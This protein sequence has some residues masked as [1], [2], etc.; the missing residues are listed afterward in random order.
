MTRAFILT[1]LVLS[2]LPLRA[3]G[4][5]ASG[6][7]QDILAPHSG[8]PAV[9]SPGGA[10][11]VVLTTP[12]DLVLENGELRYSLRAD[13][14][15]LPGD[16][17]G[18]TVPLP[19][20]VAPGRYALA[21]ADGRDRNRAAVFVLAE[22]PEV[23]ALA[24]LAGPQISAAEGENHGAEAA[25][26]KALQANAA[27]VLMSGP[28]TGSNGSKEYEA[29][30]AWIEMQTTPIFV[31]PGSQERQDGLWRSYFGAPVDG[32]RFGP[33]G[34]M[35]LGLLDAF[36]AGELD[37][38]MGAIQRLRRVLKPQ[39]WVVGFTGTNV[40]QWGMRSQLTLLADDPIDALLVGA[41]QTEASP[42]EGLMPWGATITLPAPPA[43]SGGVHIIDMT[44][45]AMLPRPDGA[46]ATPG[47]VP[48]EASSAAADAP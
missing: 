6:R 41:R 24:H 45:A 34:F 22:M 44:H 42:A 33:D 9:L 43:E 25:L 5:D 29:L 38:D 15:S 47:D 31:S 30:I 32:F 2:L 18:D 46:E 19:R 10:L 17:V 4:R 13:W 14:R 35:A 27:L 21:Y 28:L 26:A 40:M 16:R 36:G 11:E 37:G 23:Y 7:L 39:R 48:E 1:M 20:E 12:G 8:A 3:Y